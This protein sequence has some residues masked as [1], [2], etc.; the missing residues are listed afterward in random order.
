MCNYIKV[1]TKQNKNFTRNGP[2]RNSLP[3]AISCELSLRSYAAV[4]VQKT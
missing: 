2:L 1:N 4:P 3:L